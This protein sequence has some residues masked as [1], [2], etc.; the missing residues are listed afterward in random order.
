MEFVRQAVKIDSVYTDRLNSKFTA[1]TGIDN[2]NALE[3]FKKWLSKRLG[4]MVDSITKDTIPDLIEAATDIP[5][6]KE[7]LELRQELSKTSVAKYTKMEDVICS[8]G[9]A[10]G[11]LILQG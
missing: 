9:R 10:R 4:F 3:E 6:A 5:D 11:L 1:L 8:D 2:P 7:A